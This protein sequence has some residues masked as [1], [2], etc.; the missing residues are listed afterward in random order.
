MTRGASG[1]QRS[2]AAPLIIILAQPDG[3]YALAC[4]YFGYS[5]FV[6]RTP[7]RWQLGMIG[8]RS[9]GGWW[10][11]SPVPNGSGGRTAKRL[12]SMGSVVLFCAASH[13]ASAGVA[14]RTCVRYPQNHRTTEPFVRNGR[15]QPFLSGRSV[16]VRFCG[17]GTHKQWGG[18]SLAIVASC[19]IAVASADGADQGLDTGTAPRNF[20]RRARLAAVAGQPIGADAIARGNGGK[21]PFFGVSNGRVGTGA[22]ECGQKSEA[23]QRLAPSLRQP[24][25]L[26]ASVALVDLP[27]RGVGAT[28]TPPTPPSAAPFVPLSQAQPIFSISSHL[29]IRGAQAGGLDRQGRLTSNREMGSGVSVLSLADRG[30]REGAV[31]SERQRWVG[32]QGAVLSWGRSRETTTLWGGLHGVN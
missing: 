19:S 28:G 8:A 22:L 14:A 7:A 15:N 16:L 25:G 6:P 27:P 26:V 12:K 24:A 11:G 2:G 17:S 29:Q 30:Q 13:D 3:N 21:P 1:A 9:G 18:Y 10:P 5:F 31:M 4:R 23:S 32:V 20:W